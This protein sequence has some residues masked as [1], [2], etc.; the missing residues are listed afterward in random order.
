MSVSDPYKVF[1][2]LLAT[3]DKEREDATPRLRNR[4]SL[5]RIREIKTGWSWLGTLARMRQL[6]NQKNLRKPEKTCTKGADMKKQRAGTSEMQWVW[7]Q[8]WC[9]LKFLILVPQES[10]LYFIHQPNIGRELPNSK[11]YFACC[12]IFLNKRHKVSDI[13]DI[14]TGRTRQ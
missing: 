6:R 7:N 3:M 12:G 9:K 2:W 1:Y 10:Q 11:H 5:L 14:S 13:T 8:S 4:C